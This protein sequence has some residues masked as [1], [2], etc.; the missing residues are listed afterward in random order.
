MRRGGIAVAKR[1]RDGVV[2]IRFRNNYPV[3][4]HI[5]SQSTP[6]CNEGEF[7]FGALYPSIMRAVILFAMRRGGIAVA[8]RKRDGVVVEQDG[9]V[10]AGGV[11]YFIF[12]AHYM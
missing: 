2:E 12:A 5:R 1:K 6:L 9:V 8:K 11:L 10:M 3:L 4:L 7:Y